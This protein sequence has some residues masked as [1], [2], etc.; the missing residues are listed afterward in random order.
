MGYEIRHAVAR[1]ERC[2][3]VSCVAGKRETPIRVAAGKAHDFI[4]VPNNNLVR[5]RREH[6]CS[7]DDARFLWWHLQ[8]RHR[9]MGYRIINSTKR[10]NIDEEYINFHRDIFDSFGEE[11]RGRA[12]FAGD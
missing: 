4:A 5:E 6:D 7:R 8:F 12:L 3:R 1:D 10:R 2:D 9:L 11:K